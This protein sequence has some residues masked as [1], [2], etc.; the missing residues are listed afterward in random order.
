VSTT[1][2]DGIAAIFTLVPENNW[3]N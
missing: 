3:S 1:T 2:L